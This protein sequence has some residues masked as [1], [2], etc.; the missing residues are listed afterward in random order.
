MDAREMLVSLVSRLSAHPEV[1]RAIL[2]GS[3][4][5]D[6]GRA[7]SDFDLFL[8]TDDAVDTRSLYVRMMRELA[9][10]DWSIDLMILTE[11]DYA[12]KR[13]EGWTVLKSIAGEGRLLYAATRLSA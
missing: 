1:R 6:D 11:A 4:A 8:V 12:K 2:F 9:S 7:D 13:A 10:A 3:R 5:R